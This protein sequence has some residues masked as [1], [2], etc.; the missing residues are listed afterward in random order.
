MTNT[1]THK[2]LRDLARFLQ[3]FE[4]QKENLNSIFVFL[5]HLKF[6]NLHTGFATNDPKVSVTG[7]HTK[8]VHTTKMDKQKIEKERECKIQ[9]L[10]AV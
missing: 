4:I 7:K 6:Y 1:E 5:V 9:E 2:L 3:V 10:L 8:T